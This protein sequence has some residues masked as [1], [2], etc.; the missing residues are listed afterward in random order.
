MNLESLALEV[1]PRSP[2]E[3]M[4]VAVRLVV[5]HWRL[6]L[7]SW[8]VSVLPLFVIINI[9]FLE[10]YPYVAFFLI[11]FLKP[12]YDRVPLFVL[13]RVIF[14]EKT[15]WQDVVKA[16]PSLFKTGIFASLT[17]YRLDFGRAFSLPVRQLEKL[18]AKMHRTPKL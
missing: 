17:L 11:W 1:R 15:V 4:D 12:L 13:S 7:S 10:A 5:L 3:S 6:L 14:S 2:W 18:K 16:I 8:M 9:I